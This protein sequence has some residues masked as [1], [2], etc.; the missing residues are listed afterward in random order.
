MPWLLV[1]ISLPDFTCAV[2]RR[3]SFPQLGPSIVCASSRDASLTR[4]IRPIVVIGVLGISTGGAHALEAGPLATLH[5]VLL[6]AGHAGA[7]MTKSLVH[8]GRRGPN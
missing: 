8:I 6:L 3:S 4:L 5:A 7:R 1:G 2:L